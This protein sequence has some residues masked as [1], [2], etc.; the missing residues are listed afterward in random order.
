MLSVAK[1]DDAPQ[2]GVHSNHD[3]DTRINGVNGDVAIKRE[4]TPDKGK[5]VATTAVVNGGYDTSADGRPRHDQEP[6]GPLSAE[7]RS[8]MNDLPDELIHITENF[9][10][11][12]FLLTRL[13]QVS[14]NALQ[15]KVVELAKMPLPQTVMNGNSDSHG[16]NIDDTSA[17]NLSKKASLLHF[18]QDMHTKWVKALVITEWSRKAELV[19]KLIDLKAH[20][21]QQ[22][23]KYDEALDY[24]VDV[25]RNLTF[26]RLPNP[27]LKTALQVL[28]TGEV[29]WMP[30]FN[31]IE[32][33]P[34]SPE[35]QLRWI[36][37]LNTLLS[38]RLNLEEHDKVPAQFR[39]YSIDSGRVTFKVKGE[40]EV[41]LTI[42]DEDFEKQFWFIDFR[43]LFSPAPAELSEPSRAY[44]EAK[45]NEILGTDGLLGC[46]RFLHEFVLTHKIN[47]LRRQAVELSRDRWMEAVKVERL[48]R[49]VALQ[50]WS[51]RYPSNGPKSWVIIGVDSG[52]TAGPSQDQKATSRLGLRWFRENKEVKDVQIQIDD[53]ELSAEGLLKRVIARHVKHILTTIHDRLQSKARFIKREAAMS[54]HIDENEPMQ[55]VLEVQLTFVEKISVRIDPITGFFAMS[56]H[57]RM[58]FEGEYRLNYRAKD[59]AEEGMNSIESIR[60]VSAM[61]ELNRRGRSMGWTGTRQPGKIDVKSIVTPAGVGNSREPFQSLWFKREGWDPHWYL[62]ISLS[63]SGDKWWLIEL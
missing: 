20:L 33:P 43:F 63:L 60:C 53:G 58:V 1:M 7:K 23:R 16:N 29:P 45:V 3:R 35:E 48:N 12:N 56:P 54:L 46:Y 61:E 44:L 24:I 28:S 42:A 52:S 51:N 10:P 18:V 32:P 27:D 34:L 19:S 17:E 39:E 50:Y 22:M 59:P 55:S 38:I 25:K 6:E 4:I 37:D 40:F 9:I 36:N 31:Y 11:M 5:G 47:E 13:A 8:K 49:A 15:D 14:H 26:A 62:M 21:N 30:E 2:N 41:D 57:S